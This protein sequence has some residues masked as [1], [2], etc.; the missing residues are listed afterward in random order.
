MRDQVAA[1]LNKAIN[2]VLL[3]VVVLTP[4]LF[5]P[6]F[7]DFFETTKMALLVSAVLLSLLLWAGYCVVR[8]KV[9]LT[10]TPLDIPLLLVALVAGV[11]A[12]FSPT[13]YIAVYGNWPQVHSSAVAIIA[14]IL[15]YFVA[16]AHVRTRAQVGQLL[17]AL[18]ATSTV[19]AVLTLLAYFNLFLPLPFVKYQAF[20]PAGSAFNMNSLLLMVLPVLLFS[21][22]RTQKLVPPAV[23]IVL[24]TIFTTLALLTGRNASQGFGV[25]LSPAWIGVCAAYLLVYISSK[26]SELNRSL[27][28]FLAPLI[29]SAVIVIIS[30]LP[31]GGKFNVLKSRADSYPQELQ[32]PFRISWNVAASSLINT[33]FIGTGPSTFGF[34]YSQYRPAETNLTR[35]WNFRFE[36]PYNQFLKVLSTQGVLGLLAEVFFVAVAVNFAFRGLRDEDSTLT[37]ALAAGVLIGVV[38]MLTHSSSLVLMIVFMVV[39]AMLMALHKSN[40]SKVEELAIGIKASKLTDSSLVVGDILPIVIF[41][42]MFIFV[43]WAAVSMTGML[44][45]D[46]AH[47]NAL[48]NV[49][50]DPVATYNY[51]VEA[52]NLNP[53]VD[54]YRVDLAQTNFALANAIAAAKAPTEASPS[55]SLTDQDRTQIETLIQQSIREGQVA[56]LLSPRNAIN[57][58]TLANIYR[59]IAGIAQDALTFS[60]NAYGQAISLDP[61]NPL[62]RLSV[63]GVYYINKNYDLAIRFFS[64]AVNLKPD[65]ANAY[66]NLSIALRDKGDLASAQ[67][68]AERLVAILQKDTGNPDYKLASDYLADLKA[69]IATGSASQSQITPPAAEN[70]SAVTPESVNS[71]LDLGTAPKEAT[72]APV[73]K[74]Q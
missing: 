18:V 21:V 45:A 48:N 56:T 15:L 49:S 14:Y 17:Y 71:K 9:I 2:V 40:G 29:I 12:F 65:F 32:L 27:P 25:V 70:N 41:I 73:K 24:A 57:Y 33:P 66:F 31:V 6:I 42:P 72:P 54:L 46:I 62:L 59:Q 67:Q 8:G 16:T 1:Q 26:K 50:V 60:L 37:S 51:L 52:E 58:E 30:M 55:G 68:V 19:A 43:V 69:R 5:L 7:T 23:A 22:V 63:G 38:L 28:V 13:Q 74:A 4:L 53:N 36:D 39:L 44:R 61:A 3:L 64:D 47:R 11:S 20:T 34:N 10:R 35:Y